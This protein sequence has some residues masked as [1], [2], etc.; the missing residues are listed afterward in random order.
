MPHR[1]LTAAVLSVGLAICLTACGDS[2]GGAAPTPSA[3]PT[4]AP[5]ASSSTPSVVPT[6]P[7]A[8]APVPRTEAT[9][10][11]ALLALEDLPAGFAIDSEAQGDDDGTAL[12]SPDAKCAK[13]VRYFN[14]DSTPGSKLGVSRGFS[15]GQDGPFVGETLEAM[16]SA[17][18]TTAYL[19]AVKAA[20]KACPKAK[21]T[22]EGAGSSTVAVTEVRAPEAGT[23]PVAVRFSA[24]SGPLAG[25]EVTFAFAALGDVLLT[26]DFD[27]SDIEE[28]VLDA[29]AKASKVLGTSTTGA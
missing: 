3:T 2:S 28:P 26:M 19:A 15:G 12:S 5:T 20:V 21:L 24:A 1:P 17:R 13:L 9:L 4:P 10:T 16:P 14:A 18:A 8:P 6:T 29:Y 11:K 7:A 22:I 25:L 23:T 27:T